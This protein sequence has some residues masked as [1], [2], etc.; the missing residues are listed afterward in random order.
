M[1]REMDCPAPDFKKFNWLSHF[2]TMTGHN[3][4]PGALARQPSHFPAT[5]FPWLGERSISFSGWSLELVSD[6]N[7]RFAQA[8]LC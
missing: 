5:P 3:E 6:F 1:E 2:E 8:E 4:R 7:R